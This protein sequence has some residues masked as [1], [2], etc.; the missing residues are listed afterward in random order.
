MRDKPNSSNSWEA[1][2][3][4]M[5]ARADRASSTTAADGMT[6]HGLGLK[7]AKERAWARSEHQQERRKDALRGK[8][9]RTAADR[10]E[11]AASSWIEERF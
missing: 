11:L 4:S 8:L 9:P 10:R 6:A 1:R 2:T 7:T 5:T 3:E